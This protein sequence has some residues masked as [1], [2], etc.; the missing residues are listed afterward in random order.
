M[1]PGLLSAADIPDG[2][3]LEWGLL[4]GT[5]QPEVIGFDLVL[6]PQGCCQTQDLGVSWAL[7]AL[8]QCTRLGLMSLLGAGA[9]PRGHIPGG[10]AQ[11]SIWKTHP[12]LTS[13]WRPRN[14]VQ[15]FAALTSERA[16]PC[17][18]P[19]KVAGA[20]PVST[21]PTATACWAEGRARTESREVQQHA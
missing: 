9:G 14:G 2:R 1:Q 6:H 8:D 15:L 21:R 16:A 12:M 19:V 4:T 13:P 17:S 18:A 11:L 3:V 5:V 20:T 10:T 7:V